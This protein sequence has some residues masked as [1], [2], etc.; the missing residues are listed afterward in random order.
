MTTAAGRR[1]IASAIEEHEPAMERAASGLTAAVR[2]QV[3]AFLKKLNLEAQRLLRSTTQK[4]M[5]VFAKV[6]IR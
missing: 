3:L 1:L 4:E 6:E 2:T 5:R